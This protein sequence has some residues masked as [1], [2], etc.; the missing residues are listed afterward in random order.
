LRDQNSVF[1]ILKLSFSCVVCCICFAR[2][3]MFLV[4]FCVAKCMVFGFLQLC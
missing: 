4:L 1:W 2:E 3:F